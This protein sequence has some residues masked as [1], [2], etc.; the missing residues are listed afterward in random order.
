MYKFI[1]LLNISVNSNYLILFCRWY[2]QAKDL[3]PWLLKRSL[4]QIH[5]LDVD[6]VH[7][8]LVEAYHPID[9]SRLVLSNLSYS[10]NIVCSVLKLLYRH[11]IWWNNLIF[12]VV[13]RIFFN[14]C[15][16]VITIIENK[17]FVK[18]IPSCS[19]NYTNMDR[20]TMAIKN[21]LHVTAI[22]KI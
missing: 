5:P 8:C 6:K 16:I 18:E 3:L 22:P 15:V 2:P 10:E 1:V 14:N 4:V 12:I 11:E 17:K 13:F 19:S 7:T 20:I 9:K 21:F